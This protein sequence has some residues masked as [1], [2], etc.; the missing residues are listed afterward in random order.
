MANMIDATG[1]LRDAVQSTHGGAAKLA[2]SVPVRQT[3]E[4]Q[5][6]WEGMVHVFDLAGHPDSHARLRLVLTDRRKHE[7]AF[8]RCAAAASRR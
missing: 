5:T 8:L 4:S 3:F 2:Q 6:V 7:A 1:Q